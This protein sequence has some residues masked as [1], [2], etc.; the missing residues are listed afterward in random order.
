MTALGRLGNPLALA[1]GALAFIGLQLGG[2][3]RRARVLA[4]IDFD[5]LL[6][7]APQC[8]YQLAGMIFEMLEHRF[9]AVAV[10]VRPLP[11]CGVERVA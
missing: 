6:A 8:H 2:H 5:L 3:G 1:I 10:S 4:R 7:L 11:P 9:A